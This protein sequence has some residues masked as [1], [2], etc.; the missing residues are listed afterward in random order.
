MDTIRWGNTPLRDAS[1]MGSE[2]TSARLSVIEI[3]TRAGAN[4]GGAKDSS[5]ER[6]VAHKM[7]H[8]A[9]K[10]DVA[11]IRRLVQM[12]ASVN[13]CDYDSRSALH[14]ASSEGHVVVVEFLLANHA[15]VDAS[16]R[17]G[18]TPLQD[19][20][21]GGHV[22][23]QEL[24][25]GAGAATDLDES[26]HAQGGRLC[27]CAAKGDLPSI[28]KL[29][30]ANASVDACDYDRRSALHLAAAE[31]HVDVVAYLIEQKANVMAKDRF[32]ADALRDAIRGKHTAVQTMLFQYGAKQNSLEV[33]VDKSS[34]LEYQALPLH[35]RARSE[36]WMI[37]RTEIKLGHLLGEGQQGQVL[38]AD[39][40]GMPVVVK[41]LK[42]ADGKAAQ[43]ELNFM[44]E[45]SVMSTLRHPNL[46]L[47]LGAV[48]LSDPKMLVSEFLQ[49]G[50]LEDY[51][52]KRF[53]DKKRPFLPPISTVR[54]CRCCG[55]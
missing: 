1:A 32:G 8:A 43:D 12:K 27:K 20:V 38:K 25:R 14:V 33:E 35:V 29:V 3:L 7:C 5:E 42:H 36:R 16:D 40:R 46:V 51:Y 55:G 48:L 47:F 18:G 10:G 39:W 24:L 2:G 21:R 13:A 54:M 49:G 37:E 31:G 41:I 44:N 22:R 15:V 30:S 23:V 45:I 11:A 34:A 28:K 17:W 9:A 19:A 53:D 52:D 4:F 50:S 6:N 26:D